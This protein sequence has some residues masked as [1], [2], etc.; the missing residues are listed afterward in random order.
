MFLLNRPHPD[1]PSAPNSDRAGPPSMVRR[2]AD[3]ARW[4]W[5]ELRTPSLPTFIHEELDK[6]LLDEI[7][8][9]SGERVLD[10][11]CARGAYMTALAK[12]GVHP[13]GVDL[14]PR[15]VSIAR[16]AGHNAVVASGECLPVGD[17]SVDTVLCHKTLH[18]FRD[19]LQALR[20]F[21]RIL[22]PGGR[23]VFSTS[24]A[25]S[26]YSR[27][28]AMSLKSRPQPNWSRGNS[29]TINELSRRFA[30][31]GMPI[32]AIYSCNLVWPLVYRVCDRWIIPNE[33]MRRYNRWIRRVTRMPLRTS[34]PLGAALDY[35]VEAV[36]V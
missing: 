9:R 6:A 22:R 19:P 25:V 13:I 15:S 30:E 2:I 24:N 16:A 3:R 17:A 36:R 7:S 1:R 21:R 28:Q 34:Y 18:L 31:C 29:L 8:W 32:R 27:V 33:W 23:V 10:V 4:E 11:G 5:R 12:R 14:S 35:L 20:E 26:P